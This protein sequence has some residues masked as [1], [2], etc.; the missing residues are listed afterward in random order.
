[1]NANDANKTQIF[2]NHISG[3][4]QS[5]LLK[6]KFIYKAQKKDISTEK[7]DSYPLLNK[8]TLIT[9]RLYY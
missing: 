1:M 3:K 5:L 9:L 8:N 7:K 4:K 6:T 2:I